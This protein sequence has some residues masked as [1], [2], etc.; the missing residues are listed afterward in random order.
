M[1][2][3]PEDGG[4]V[5]GGMS[6]TITPNPVNDILDRFD[7]A[8]VHRVMVATRWTW[9]KTENGEGKVPTIAD[10]RRAART[11]VNFVYAS[12]DPE[13]YISSGGFVARKDSDGCLILEFV[14][15]SA[16]WCSNGEGLS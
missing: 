6:T 12:R 5:G 13:A 16:A 3:I 9:H 8:R 14:V 11:Y 1:R 15:E 7:F 2:G 10:L 4:K